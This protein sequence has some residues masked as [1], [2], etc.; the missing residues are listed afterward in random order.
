[1]NE[2]NNNNIDKNDVNN[3]ISYLETH[4]NEIGFENYYHHHH[5]SFTYIID[6]YYTKKF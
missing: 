5:M 4:I 1:M 6:G 2:A 3:S